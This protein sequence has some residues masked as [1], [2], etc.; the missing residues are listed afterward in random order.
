MGLGQISWF[1][2]AAT[3]S[4][5]AVGAALLVRRALA[6]RGPRRTAGL[7]LSGLLA[8]GAL[9]AVGHLVVAPPEGRAAVLDVVLRGPLAAA[10]VTVAA[11]VAMAVRR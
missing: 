4:G 9:V 1:E 2:D 10:S 11:V 8:A 7:L 5:S 3:A 6:A